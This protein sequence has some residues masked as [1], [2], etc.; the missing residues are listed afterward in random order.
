MKTRP[1]AGFTLVEVLVVIAIIGVLVGLLVP[2][3][4]MAREA[5][6]RTSCSNQ[7]KQLALAVKLHEDTHRIYPTG[8]WGADWVGDPDHGFG[9]KQPG[10]WVYNV[11]PYIEQSSLREVGSGQPNSQRRQTLGRVMETPIEVLV[12]PSRRL[13]RAYP[14]RGPTPIENADPPKSAAKSDYAINRLISFERS[15]VIVSEIQL[16][17]GLSKTFMIGEKSV[18]QASY[19]LGEAAGDRLSAFQGDC[20]DIARDVAGSPVSDR[21]GGSGFGSA[22]LGGANFAYCDGAVRLVSFDDEP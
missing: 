8:G 9:V 16:S 2:A 5:A 19:T 15:E 20:D 11:L 21:L 7:L 22:H 12:C 4:Q 17:D 1:V 18:P 13:P 6:R 14:Y 10:G 3:T